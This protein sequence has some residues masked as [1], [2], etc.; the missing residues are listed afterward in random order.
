VRQQATIMQPDPEQPSPTLPAAAPAKIRDPRLD[1]FRGL[2]LFIILVSHTRSDVLADWIPARFGLSDAANMFVF[3]SGYAGGIAFGGVYRRRGWLLG[4]ARIALRLWQLYIAQLAI[5]MLVAAMAVAADLLLGSANDHVGVFQL[6][7]LFGSPREALLAIVTLTYVPHY[8]DILPVYIA[9]IAMVPAAV[10]L[11]RLSPLL[12]PVVSVALWG[13]ATLYGWD[14][15]NEPSEPRGWF[16]DPF[17]WQVMFFSG[18]SIS[19]RWVRP[20]PINRAIFWAAVAA[21]VAGLAVTQPFIFQTVPGLDAAQIWVVAHADK[22][23]VDPL[24][25]LHFLA[26][27]Y[28]VVALLKG[29]ENLLLKPW[30]RPIVRCGQQSLAVFLS[31]IVLAYLAGIAFDALGTGVAAQIGVNAVAFALTLAVAYLVGW[32]KAKPWAKEAAS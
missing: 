16:F 29:H 31:G 27:A 21:L 19:M 10:A 2:S 7:Y 17:C 14:L 28:V 15:P 8:L 4:T 1:F 25:Y 24:Q 22:T 20:P 30:A 32:F 23:M 26:L 9:V 13:L 12:V 6:D 3:V 5:T 18:F 11:A